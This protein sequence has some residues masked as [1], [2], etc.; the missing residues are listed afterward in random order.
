MPTVKDELGNTVSEQ[1]YTPEG[2]SKAEQI[3]SANP[4]WEVD[5]APGGSVDAMN[6]NVTEYAGGG[7]TGYSKIGMYKE[8]GKIKERKPYGFK[9]PEFGELLTPWNI[10]KPRKKK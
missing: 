3:A 10:F 4:N 9:F 2:E 7:K 8:G 5:Y 6:R 1:P